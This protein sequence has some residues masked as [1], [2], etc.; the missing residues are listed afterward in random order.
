MFLK[1]ESNATRKIR[2]ESAT[3]DQGIVRAA[4]FLRALKLQR[5]VEASETDSSEDQVRR[6]TMA[7]SVNEGVSSVP[8]GPTQCSDHH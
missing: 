6:L 5:R 3:R 2:A 4:Y 1:Y 7:S 8:F